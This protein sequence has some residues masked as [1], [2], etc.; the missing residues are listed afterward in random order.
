MLKS[1]NVPFLGFAWLFLLGIDMV[2]S[3]IV[4]PLVQARD[5]NRSGHR[6]G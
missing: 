6:W 3:F 1:L 5:G 4:L 2:L